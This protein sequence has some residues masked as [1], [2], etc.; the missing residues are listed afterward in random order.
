VILV[1]GIFPICAFAQLDRDMFKK[2]QY[3]CYASEFSEKEKYLKCKDLFSELMTFASD[4]EKINWK[5]FL[6][7]VK[8]A[9]K[10]DKEK[11]GELN[12]KRKEWY[13][14]DCGGVFDPDRPAAYRNSIPESCLPLGEMLEQL[15]ET[16]EATEVYDKGCG[17]KYLENGLKAKEKRPE[18]SSRLLGNYACATA[19]EIKKNN[20][21][22]VRTCT[23][24]RLI[25]CVRYA[26]IKFLAGDEVSTLAPYY[27]RACEGGVDEGCEKGRQRTE[28]TSTILYA[29]IL[30]IGLAAFI[31]TNMMF[32][33]E[34]QFK[35]QEQLE[36]GAKKDD[37]KK[38]GIVLQYS[39]PFFKRYISPI[40]G[41]MK[42]KKVIKEKYKRKL[43]SAGLNEIMTT[44]DF[45]SFKLFLIVGFPIV[46]LIVKYFMEAD[47]PLTAI[48]VVS[49]IGYFYPDLWISGKIELRQKEILMNMPFAVDMLALS[50]EAGLDFIAAMSKVTEKAKPSALVDEFNTIIKEIKIGANRAEALRNMAWRVDM[51]NVTSFT[52]TLIAADSVGAS[53]GPILKTLS[54]EIRQKKSSEIEKKG[55]TAAT[56]IL[57]PMLFLIVPAVFI[58]VAA[59]IIIELMTQG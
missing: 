57:F 51:V 59:P 38:H 58:I 10:L 3:E 24:E 36:S 47:W 5:E 48:P 18:L 20:L 34:S 55:A 2:F 46:F 28:E 9:D 8:G 31:V 12:K 44:E 54:K 39:R 56:K 45:F 23:T 33:D 17:R 26:D 27:K 15:K 42:Y 30:L 41:A 52:A 4:E 11:R 22:G 40:V 7:S 49:V 32:Q 35:A 16:E 19:P 43:S 25:S 21:T 53:I 13:K 29:G 1:F 50:V 37:I 6:K 14:T